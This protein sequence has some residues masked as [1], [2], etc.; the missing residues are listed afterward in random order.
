MIYGEGVRLRAAERSDLPRFVEWLNDPEVRQYISLYLP[1]SQ[2]DEEQWFDSMQKRPPAEHVLVIE[3]RQPESQSWLPVGNCAFMDIDW[4]N[5]SAEFGI[6]IGEK[7]HWNQGYG[8]AAVRLLVRH[9]FNTLNLQRIFL[10]VFETN[11][12]AIRAYEKAGFVREGRMR[13][14]EFLDGRYVDVLLMSVLRSEW[15]PDGG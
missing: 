6:F 2:G 1:L 11:P 12:R 7:S 3:I 14:A 5:R 15:Q 13:Q 8:T 4:R 9:G 10:R